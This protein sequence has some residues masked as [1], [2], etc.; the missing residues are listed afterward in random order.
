MI[1][2]RKKSE[3][4]TGKTSVHV[5]NSNVCF[6]MPIYFAILYKSFFFCSGWNDLTRLHLC[7]ACMRNTRE[8]DLK[9]AIY[10]Y[11]FPWINT[12]ES[13]LRKITPG[14]SLSFVQ[15]FD[16][17][18]LL[19]YILRDWLLLKNIYVMLGCMFPAAPLRTCAFSLSSSYHLSVV[20]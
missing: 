10:I 4:P 2:Y 8:M 7:C 5:S 3:V 1:L 12:I 20:F 19:Y 6:A 18:C 16:K 13:T 15:V 11:V 17:E 9:H 14:E